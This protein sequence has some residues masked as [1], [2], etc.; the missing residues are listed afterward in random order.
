PPQAGGAVRRPSVL[1]V[2]QNLDAGAIHLPRADKKTRGPRAASRV[3]YLE[4]PA[5]MDGETLIVN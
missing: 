4:K 1:A 3:G 5:E 2:G